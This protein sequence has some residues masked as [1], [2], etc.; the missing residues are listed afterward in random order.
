MAEDE[1][2]LLQVYYRS[3]RKLKLHQKQK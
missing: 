1:Q 2:N 3:A